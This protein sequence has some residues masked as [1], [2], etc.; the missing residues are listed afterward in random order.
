MADPFTLFEDERPA[1]SNAAEFTVSELSRAVKRTVEDGFGYVRVRGEI[2]GF[3]GRHSSGHCYF[4]LK[5]ADATIDA[6]VW[7]GAW[8]K[9]AT[10]PEEGLEVI[11]TGRL[12]TYPRSSKYQIVVDNLE[13]AGLGALMKL[14]EER[15]QKLAAEGLF[16]EARRRPLPLMPR[17]I[18]VVT[19]PTGAVIRD[20]L[21][22][23]AD[24]FPAHVVV[25]P[26]RVQG[27]TSAAEVTAAVQGFAGDYGGPRPDVIIVAR[28]GGSVEDLWGYNDEALV[29]AVAASPIP[30]VSAVGHETDWTLVDHAADHRAPTPTGAAERVVPVRA[31]CLA[32]L[33]DRARRLDTAMA[34]HLR[35]R[36]EH[37]RFLSR[38]LPPGP[39]LVDPLR[40]RLD[41]AADRALA[42]LFKQTADARHRWLVATRHLS[43]AIAHRPVERA[44]DRLAM[45]SARLA[46]AADGTLADRRAAAARTG[47]RLSPHLLARPVAD[48]RDRLAR[49]VQRRDR[50]ATH[51]LATLRHRLTGIDKL[52][53]ALSY[54]A[55]LDR[56]FA[57]VRRGDDSTVRSAAAVGKGEALQLQF[58]DGR[59][60]VVEGSGPARSAAAQS[61]TPRR[62]SRK[63]DDRQGTLL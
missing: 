10:K 29:R 9:L 8:S 62:R 49:A 45:A 59:V 13:P 43:P 23:I 27:E 7:K 38:G 37:L 35:H 57:L 22:R 60:A 19:S 61:P 28:G 21:H 2:G 58:A 33:A 56:G 39:T 50:V 5:D 36:A 26:V 40:Q 53:G 24:R 11:A 34:T 12:T 18:G 52:L 25:W 6:V 15:R 63:V 1:S 20:I 41:I 44:G 51:L 47:A 17:V 16:D 55:V 54:T 32:T 48:Q 42:A 46:R 14:L 30:I 4:S 31:E 3:R